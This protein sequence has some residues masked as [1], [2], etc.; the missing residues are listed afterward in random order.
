MADEPIMSY[1]ALRQAY[2]PEPIENRRR[3]WLIDNV[4][5]P[6]A[7]CTE[8]DDG[9]WMC[10]DDVVSEK[11]E[12]AREGSYELMEY[13]FTEHIAY[14]VKNWE[15]LGERPSEYNEEIEN[16][17]GHLVY[18]LMEQFT[19]GN[20]IFNIINDDVR[21]NNAIAKEIARTELKLPTEIGNL[22]ASYLGKI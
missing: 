8:Y 11:P 14:G 17:N 1:E 15:K 19:A 2:K 5:L 21:R 13:L 6:I 10:C 22:V 9:Y 3:D 16:A 12:I 7:E 20:G 18:I 4:F